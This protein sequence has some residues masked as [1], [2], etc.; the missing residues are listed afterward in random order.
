[1][2]VI[3]SMTEYS[4]C[5]FEIF[6]NNVNQ[7]PILFSPSDR[8]FYGC[9]LSS[10]IVSRIFYFSLWVSPTHL[11]VTPERTLLHE[12]GLRVPTIGKTDS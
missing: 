7:P 12:G 1:M 4:N 2:N 9:P 3:R 8:S 11:L 6:Y 10:S 5:R